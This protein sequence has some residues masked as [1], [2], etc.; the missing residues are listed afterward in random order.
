MRNTSIC[1]AAAAC[2]L[3][4][5]YDDDQAAELFQGT[6]PGQSAYSATV[7]GNGDGLAGAAPMTAVDDG[8]ISMQL[9]SG[10]ML[11]FDDVIL[12]TDSRGQGT[13]ATASL[14]GADCVVPVDGGTATFDVTSGSSTSTGGTSLAVSIGGQLTSWVGTP[15]T[16][17]M[18][19]MFQ[20]EWIHN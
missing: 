10:C 8:D 15:A 17:Y 2:A 1:F 12:A 9:G 19:V 13:S 18:T 6:F 3:A 14:A 11:A 5:C 7:E 16:G 4:G 20:G